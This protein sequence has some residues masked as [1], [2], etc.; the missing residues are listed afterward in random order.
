MMAAMTE[1]LESIARR[2]LREA[3]V[4]GLSLATL[5]GGRI[6]AVLALGSRGPHD[7]APVDAHTVFEA[8][9]LTKPLVAWL[10][11]Q[12]AG[13][14]RLD[15]DRP[16]FD[17]CG[18]YVPDDP[19]ARGITARHVLSHTGGLPNLVTEAAP[20][21]TYFAPGERFSYA[22]S[23]FGY[24][25][26]AMRTASGQNLQLM[27]YRAV[28]RPLGM[29]DS[30]LIWQPLY[31]G[32]HAAGHDEEGQACPKRR[33]D[34]P[35]ASW[36]LHTTAG[37]YAR[38]VQAVL[39]GRGLPEALLQEWFRPVAAPASSG[40]AED[41]EGERP[42]S[43]DVAWGLGWGLEPAQGCFFHW[44]HSPGFRAFVLA[45][46]RSGDGVV[47]LANGANGLDF[48]RELVA[49]AMGGEHP[50]LRWMGL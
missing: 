50:S 40:N 14:G 36:S 7:A 44:G 31:E 32:N 17:L 46:R 38:F 13:Q 21:R 26:R 15:L 42:R 22:S 30:S 37:D 24:L 48:G 23:A 25:Q 28:F 27:A 20:L 49:A 4:P 43:T 6:D 3:R 19:R 39:A 11:L 8:A 1:A 34:K 2:A 16:L 45:N 12:L 10:A 5:H 18:E 35:H 9:S 33:V 29:A 41:L 47:W